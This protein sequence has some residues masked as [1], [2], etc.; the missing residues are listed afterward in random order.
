MKCDRP[1][2]CCY[3]C[4]WNISVKVWSY[5]YVT[6]I[7]FPPS[8]SVWTFSKCCSISF[9]KKSLCS[10]PRVLGSERCTVRFGTVQCGT[11]TIT[12]VLLCIV[13]HNGEETLDKCIKYTLD[14]IHLDEN[15]AA[16]RLSAWLDWGAKF[17]L[18]SSY[19]LFII[20]NVIL[21]GS[22][23]R[24]QQNGTILS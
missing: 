14:L 5:N 13:Q 2:N 22:R 20:H 9:W 21:N 16:S 3:F 15:I 8:L 4:C 7:A 11:E 19:S 1:I 23:F 12:Y 6:K 18:L 10:G 24:K 17:S